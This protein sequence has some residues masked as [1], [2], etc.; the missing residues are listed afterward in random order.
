M[1]YSGMS[2][3]SE[4]VGSRR[5]LLLTGSTGFVGR[6]LLAAI[7]SE[8]YQIAVL[9]HEPAP[10]SKPVSTVYQAD[11][12]DD[13]AVK[14][15]IADWRPQAVVHL[16]AQAS[17]GQAGIDPG[18]TWSVNLCGSLALARALAQHA[19]DVTFL[20]SSSAEVYGTSFN[21]GVVTEASPLRPVN[22]YSRSKVAAEWMLT[23]VLPAAARLIVVRAVNH[24]GPFQ[25]ERFAIPAFAAQ[26]ARIEA[27]CSPPVLMVGDLS[28]ERDFLDVSDV[29]DAYLGL[30]DCAPR[31]PARS[32][33]NVS[34]GRAV[35]MATLVE[36]LCGLSRVPVEVRVDPA[37]VR[38]NSVPRAVADPSWLSET[39]GWR[40]GRNIKSTVRSVLDYWRSQVA[41]A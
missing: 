17:V 28:A 7:G 35:S 8:R 30:L 6:H 32:V 37:R 3:G 11:L 25:D 27:G 13:N 9:G 4:Q 38:P 29:V 20:F 19:A 40:P 34:S 22:A 39:I 14:A 36:T 23:E 12:R 15:A 24:T 33:F 18:S 10:L 26:I 41:S 16:A 2:A 5:R 31:L 1:Q 21:D